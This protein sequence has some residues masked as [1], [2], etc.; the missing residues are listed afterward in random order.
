MKTLFHIF[1]PFL[2][3]IPKNEKM[4]P[5]IIIGKDKQKSKANEPMDEYPDEEKSEPPLFDISRAPPLS[6]RA[7]W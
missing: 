4:A 3:F 2:K 5:K 6:A 1:I 7:V